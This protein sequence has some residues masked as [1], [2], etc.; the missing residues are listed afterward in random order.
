M[1]FFIPSDKK[2]LGRIVPFVYYED[3]TITRLDS[4]PLSRFDPK[5]EKI[6]EILNKKGIQYKI[7]A[8]KYRKRA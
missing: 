2:E 1:S 5:V 4:Q 7:H 6:I 3:G 8:K